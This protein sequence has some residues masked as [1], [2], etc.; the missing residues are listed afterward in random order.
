MAA[1]R[2]GALLLGRLL[3][4]LFFF[5]DGAYKFSGKA[6]PSYRQFMFDSFKAAGVYNNYAYGGLADVTA[7]CFCLAEV[8]GA[9]LLAGGWR[10]PGALL[11]CVYLVVEN[12]LQNGEFLLMRGVDM[13]KLI[14]FLRNLALVGG[15]IVVGAYSDGDEGAEQPAG[16]N[17]RQ[18]Q[19]RKRRAKPEFDPNATP[20]KEL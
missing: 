14:P 16:P 4:A 17:S 12:G 15:L 20:L 18:L 6:W 13:L 8:A 3:A 11:L 19:L 9:L 7:A 2:H 5:A 10:E 1:R